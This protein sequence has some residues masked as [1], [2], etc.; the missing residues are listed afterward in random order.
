MAAVD[1]IRVFGVPLVGS[2][3]LADNNKD[4]L[5]DR[6]A[7]K[8]Q[9]KGDYHVIHGD[10]EIDRLVDQY[11]PSFS[12]S[13]LMRRNIGLQKLPDG[14]NELKDLIRLTTGKISVALRGSERKQDAL[15]RYY[16][17]RALAYEKLG[18]YDLSYEEYSLCIHVDFDYADAYFNRAGISYLKKNVKMA[19]EDINKA[20]AINP[21]N[22]DYLNNRMFFFRELKDFEEAAK[23]AGKP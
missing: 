12:S 7:R 15:Q 23:T 8:E 5:I 13:V 14:H 16:F 21:R 4:D 20:I 1:H 11:K 2:P 10:Y 9:L 19:I 6:K 22:L 17:Q 18:R 3:K